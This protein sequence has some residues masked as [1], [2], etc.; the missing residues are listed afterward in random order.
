MGK[1]YIYVRFVQL[2]VGIY[3]IIPYKIMSYKIMSQ[4][5]FA[6]FPEFNKPFI[7]LS[8]LKSVMCDSHRLCFMEKISV[9]AVFSCKR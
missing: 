9:S 7:K 2:Y 1:A 6:T 5:C 3:K 4:K 8:G